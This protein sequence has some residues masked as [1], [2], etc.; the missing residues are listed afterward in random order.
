MELM[1]AYGRE[2][3]AGLGTTLKLFIISLAIGFVLAAAVAAFQIRFPGIASRLVWSLMFAIRGI[4]MLLVLYVV[5]Y[6]F[7]LLPIIRETILWNV[8]ASPFWCAILCLSIVETAYTS[9][10]MRGAYYQTPKE[11]IEAAR[12]LGLS[13]F[14]TFRIAILPAML[15]NGFPPYTT[16]VIMLCKT[17]ALAF[18][19]TV[20]DVMGVA[21]EIRARTLDI[22]RPLLIAGCIYICIVIVSR[23]ILATIFSLI[24]VSGNHRTGV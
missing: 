15:R 12:S 5:Y 21:N 10:I 20:M 8:F 3:L 4:P 6:G 17:T 19:V 9:E 18:T 22:Y 1:I 16:E 2:I 11:Q 7:P 14:Q 24:A 13:G 23:T